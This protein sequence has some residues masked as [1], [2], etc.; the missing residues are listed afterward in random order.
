MTENLHSS[1]EE[2]DKEVVK[3]VDNAKEEQS[4]G[5]GPKSSDSLSDNDI[6][7]ERTSTSE[8]DSELETG[9][10]AGPVRSQRPVMNPPQKRKI[11][12]QKHKRKKKIFKPIIP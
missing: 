9:V 12:K 5:E 8:L 6:Q 10:K 4:G 7:P 3:E 1:D 2:D 11:Q